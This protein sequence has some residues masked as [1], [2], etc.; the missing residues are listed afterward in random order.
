MMTAPTK[1][2]FETL[3]LGVAAYLVA[4]EKLALVDAIP[5]PNG[6]VSFVFKDA[7]GEGPLLETQFLSGQALV[8]GVR[9]HQQLRL[10]RRLAERELR[11]A[12][13]LRA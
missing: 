2:T 12:N 6:K 8:S 4:A 13:L 10:L 5:Q 1:F 9:F 3:D 7:N 11:S